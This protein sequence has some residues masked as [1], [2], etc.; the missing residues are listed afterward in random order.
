MIGLEPNKMCAKRIEYLQREFEYVISMR[1][2]ILAKKKKIVNRDYDLQPENAN[3]PCI[4]ILMDEIMFIILQYLPL[5]TLVAV[6]G[7]CRRW[8][9]LIYQLFAR[10]KRF[11]FIESTFN[12]GSNHHHH[13]P[14]VTRFGSNHHRHIPELK[15]AVNKLCLLMGSRITELTIDSYFY[16][17]SIRDIA[18]FCP[19]LEALHLDNAYMV[20]HG[21]FE[22]LGIYCKNLKKLVTRNHYIFNDVDLYIIFQNFPTIEY[23]D[24]QGRYILCKGY[25]FKIVPKSLKVLR[26]INRGELGAR[27]KHLGDR[28]PKLEQLHLIRENRTFQMEHLDYVIA[29]CPLLKMIVFHIPLGP[30]V[31]MYM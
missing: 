10:Y 2:N 15:P 18:L 19:L 16:S 4:H 14:A 23:L 26:F 20:N 30:K 8:Q 28:C 13:I 11:N 21:D 6:E 3:K 27:V 12:I 7:V 17:R 5:K 1:E 25:A 29:K 31:T 9:I 24:I 22:F